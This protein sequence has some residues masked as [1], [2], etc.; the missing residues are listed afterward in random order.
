[1]KGH[2]MAQGK[3]KA[4]KGKRR[5]KLTFRN[6]GI[7]IDCKRVSDKDLCIAIKALEH[8]I[9]ERQMASVDKFVDELF[10]NARK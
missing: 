2:K 6:N 1:M 8:T 5:V 4:T 10:K 3:K 7:E 9:Q